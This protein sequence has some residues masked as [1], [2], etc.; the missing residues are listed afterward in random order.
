MCKVAVFNVMFVDFGD[1][2]NLICWVFSPDVTMLNKLR[3]L[4]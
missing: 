4:H 2:A 1:P 3:R